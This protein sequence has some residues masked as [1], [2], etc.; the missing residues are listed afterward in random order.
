MPQLLCGNFEFEYCLGNRPLQQLPRKLQEINERLLP[1][2]LALSHPGDFLWL[3]EPAEILVTRQPQLLSQL[4]WSQV[5][6]VWQ[7][8]QLA[9]VTDLKLVP[10][11]W[12]QK[13]IHWGQQQGWQVQAPAFAVVNW[14]N[15]RRTSCQY[16]QQWEIAPAGLQPLSS[17]EDVQQWLQRF[18]PEQ[19]WIIKAEFGMSSRERLPGQGNVLSPPQQQ[20]I[21]KRLRNND[22]LFGEPWLDSVE[23]CSFHYQISPSGKVHYCGQMQLITDDYGRYLHNLPMKEQTEE[24]T[25]DCW[26]M[27]R[28]W[29]FRLAE[30]FAQQGYF[31]PL[32]IDSMRYREPTGEIRERPLQDINAR[33]TMGRCALERIPS[34]RQN[35]LIAPPAIS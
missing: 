22:V 10:W 23:E 5:T 6:P 34:N 33:W 35:R 16:E 17:A 13:L 9:G 28:E 8:A 14:A 7:T 15:S 2:I 11:G 26:P 25:V 3:P 32:G 31:G 24:Q 1:E 27:S 12:T 18:S 4:E 30:S 19:R 21:S 29:T 20:W